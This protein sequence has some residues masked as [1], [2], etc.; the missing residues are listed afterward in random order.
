MNKKM[1]IYNISYYPFE[2]GLEIARRRD[3]P[4]IDEVLYVDR[5]EEE[6]EPNLVFSCF[7]I[8]R[9]NRVF[10]V[11]RSIYFAPEKSWIGSEEDL[12]LAVLM[13]NQEPVAI[14]DWVNLLYDSVYMMDSCYLDRY[15]TY[16]INQGELWTLASEDLIKKERRRFGDRVPYLKEVF[17]AELEKLKMIEEK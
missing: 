8:Y 13:K 5:R 11:R 17:K 4:V 6:A 12:F 16:L 15:L 10:V 2:A 7:V 1:E 9:F 14:V 3:L